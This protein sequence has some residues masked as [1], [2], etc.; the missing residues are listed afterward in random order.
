MAP[1][2]DRVYIALYLRGGCP[3]MPGSEDMV[4]QDTW[5]TLRRRK[6]VL[7]SHNANANS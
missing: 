4:R 1:N 6:P 5:L 2:K 3:Q 7:K